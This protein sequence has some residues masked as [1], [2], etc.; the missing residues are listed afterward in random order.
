METLDYLYDLISVNEVTLIGYRFLDERI[1][2]EI[3]SNLGR[4]KT[5]DL[6]SSFSMKSIIRDM[7]IGQVL[8]DEQKIDYLL[9]DISDIRNL[10]RERNSFTNEDIVPISSAIEETIYPIRECLRDSRNGKKI[11][12][13]K[14]IITCPLN[15]TMSS[16]HKSGLDSF[17]GGSTPLYCSDLGLMITQKNDEKIIKIIKNRNGD[18]D[19]II[20]I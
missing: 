17:M 20:K 3:I 13:I 16:S 10:F 4:T 1:K 15:T 5:I 14:L 9:I 18:S 8:N 12:D 7:K 2:D 19:K 11:C 6:S